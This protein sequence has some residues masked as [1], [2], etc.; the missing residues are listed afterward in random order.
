MK[1]ISAE[2]TPWLRDLIATGYR[3]GIPL[4]LVLRRRQ[5][6]GPAVPTSAATFHL[7]TG[8]VVCVEVDEEND[9]YIRGCLAEGSGAVGLLWFETTDGCF[10]GINLAYVDA[11]NWT[12]AG[13]LATDP[14]SWRHDCITMRFSDGTSMELPRITG[15]TIEYL[16]GA[17]IR[18]HKKPFHL[19]SCADGRSVSINCENLMS[20]T[21]PATWL[22]EDN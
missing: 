22:D 5:G 10:R 7:R 16:K 2:Q 9:E 15:D 17:T 6:K 13:S 1:L 3:M 20:V 4:G 14:R 21:M 19:L 11:V 18:A 12:A 8:E